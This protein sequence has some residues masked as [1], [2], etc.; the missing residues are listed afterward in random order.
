MFTRTESLG[1]VWLI[2]AGPGDVEHLTLKAVRALGEAQVVLI[3]DLVNRDVL[4][5]VAPQAR[6]IEVGK[7]GGCR[8]T[9]QAFIERKMVQLARVALQPP[10]EARQDL[11]IINQLARRLGLDWNYQHPKQVFE[12]MRQSMDSIAGITW[13]RLERENSVT[14]PC[15]HEGDPGEPVVFID[16]FPTEDGRATLVPARLVSADELPDRDYPYVLITG[17]QLEHWHTGAMTRRAQ[18]LDAIEPQATVSLTGSDLK[19]LGA[20]AGDWL[21]V[22]SRRGEI[23]LRARCDDGLAPGNIFIPFAYAEAAANLLTNPALD[24][25]GK[26]PEFKYCAVRI[27][28]V[29]L[30]RGTP[31]HP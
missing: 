2:G 17:R 26:I 7:R 22:A 31:I 4:Q 13:E 25:F 23:R 18:A 15:H 5:F 16:S 14:Y 27:E 30:A 28:R 20:Q 3:D 29:E 6:V 9:P 24:P 12:E 1:K 8:S 21:N 19:R 10:G 11:W